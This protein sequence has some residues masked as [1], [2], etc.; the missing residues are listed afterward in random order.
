MHAAAGAQ[1]IAGRGLNG[2]AENR[3]QDAD[4][5]AYAGHGG[6]MDFQLPSVVG[7]KDGRKRKFIILACTSKAFFQSY[8]KETGSEPLLWTTGLMAPE[9]YTL[10]AALNGWFA[11]QGSESIRMSAARAY[12]R[13]QRCGEQAARNLLASTW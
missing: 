1:P 11:G 7:A 2:T 13:Y 9:A 4:L 8:M 3:F 5:V 12:N 6:L 10:E